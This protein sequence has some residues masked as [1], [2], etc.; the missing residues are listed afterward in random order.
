MLCIPMLRTPRET[1]DGSYDVSLLSRLQYFLLTSGIPSESS[2]F[3]RLRDI[4]F[5]TSK[6]LRVGA[7]S[8]SVGGGCKM[9]RFSL[10]ISSSLF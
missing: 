3:I 1:V 9:G 8:F 4:S 7:S 5:R 10:D 6:T 2:L